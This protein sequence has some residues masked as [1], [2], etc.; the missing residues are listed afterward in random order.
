[1]MTAYRQ[2]MTDMVEEA[3]NNTAYACLYKPLDIEK[4]LRLIDEI[5]ERKQKAG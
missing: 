5:W 1:M 4:M 3:L 2:E